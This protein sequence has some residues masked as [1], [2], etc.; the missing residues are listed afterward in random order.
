MRI[1]DNIR[2]YIYTYV[3]K[4]LCKTVTNS[5][6]L[7][8]RIHW[9]WVGRKMYLNKTNYYIQPEC[10]ILFLKTQWH[11]NTTRITRYKDTT[12][13]TDWQNDSTLMLQ[14]W[15]VGITTWNMFY[16]VL[17][18]WGHMRHSRT[19]IILLKIFIISCNSRIIISWVSQN[20]CLLGSW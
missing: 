3:S 14:D 17:L 20:F 7:R 5:F 19:A 15:W 4:S 9:H 16:L 6:N 1:Q 2:H 13:A 12:V 11:N 18:I 8:V 10:F